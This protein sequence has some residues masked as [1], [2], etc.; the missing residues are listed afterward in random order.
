MQPEHQLPNNYR[1]SVKAI[2]RHADGRIL[3]AKES[4]DEWQLPGGGLEHGETIE[5]GLRREIHEELDVEV[6][7]FDPRPRFVWTLHTPENNRHILWLVFEVTL[8]GTPKTT[9]HTSAVEYLDIRT[10]DRSQLGEFFQ[11]VYNEFL[12]LADKKKPHQAMEQV[13]DGI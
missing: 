8:A 3:M 13:R 2:I 9:S 1:T 10:I 12:L 11:P 4:S 5:Q 7:S 6:A